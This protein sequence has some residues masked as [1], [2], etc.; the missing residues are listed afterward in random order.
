MGLRRARVLTPGDL[1][2]LRPSPECSCGFC[3]ELD[4][5]ARWAR[6]AFDRWSLAGISLAPD[7]WI[8]VCPPDALPAHHPLHEHLDN[9]RSAALLACHGLGRQLVQS[10]AARLVALDVAVLE[11]AGARS[12]QNCLTPSADFL[13]S[14]GFQP[15]EQ[16]DWLAAGAQRLQLHLDRTISWQPALGA[17]VQHLTRW[18]HA[19][20]GPLPADRTLLPRS[21]PSRHDVAECGTVDL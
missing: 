9:P 3:G 11:A 14:L 7:V 13:T 19:P 4:P 20:E 12:E 16:V 10:L 5:D 6:A 21:E 15:C 18:A 2:R 8:L 17:V 1:A